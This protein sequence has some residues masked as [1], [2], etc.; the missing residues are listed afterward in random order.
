MPEF[1]IAAILT[2]LSFGVLDGIINGNPYARRF[3]EVYQPIARKKINVP[4]GVL[5]DI[6]YGFIISGVFLLILPVLPSENGIVKGLVFGLGM[7]FFRVIMG[8]VSNWMMFKIPVN[9]ILYML[10]TGFIE[11]IILGIINGLIIK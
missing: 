3:M 8:A 11:M 4:A 6:V 9:T 10:V 5:I 7:W 1:I 2:G